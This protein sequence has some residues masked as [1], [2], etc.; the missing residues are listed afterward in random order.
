MGMDFEINEI[1][2]Q[3]VAKALVEVLKNDNTIEK[4]FELLAGDSSVEDAIQSV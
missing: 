3:D 4:E 2:R 1:P